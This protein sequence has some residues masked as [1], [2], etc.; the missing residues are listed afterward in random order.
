[1]RS[2]TQVLNYIFTYTLE[3]ELL[4]LGARQIIFEIFPETLEIL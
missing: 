3:I 1:M 2:K 4:L